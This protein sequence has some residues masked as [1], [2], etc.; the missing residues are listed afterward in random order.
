M[1]PCFPTVG[2][3]VLT[4]DVTQQFLAQGGRESM[5]RLSEKFYL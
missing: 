3:A 2:V 4:S 1:T 5:L